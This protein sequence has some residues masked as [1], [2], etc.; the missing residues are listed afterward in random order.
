MDGN[1]STGDDGGTAPMVVEQEQVTEGQVTQE[2][3]ME[4]YGLDEES[5]VFTD[6]L[7]YLEGMSN[8]FTKIFSPT[9]KIMVLKA[10]A[11]GV[12]YIKIEREDG[13]YIFD[14]FEIDGLS[15]AEIVNLINIKI[16]TADQVE[17]REARE[18]RGDG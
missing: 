3:V 18:A 14:R 9:Y 13:S 1:R 6:T 12:V 8:R 16:N 2:Q 7:G 5:H 10:Q 17:A 4:L 11:G 15:E